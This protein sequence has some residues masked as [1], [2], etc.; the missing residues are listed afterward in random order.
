M[1]ETEKEMPTRQEGSILSIESSL[2]GSWTHAAKDG[3]PNLVQSP[4]SV[5]RRSFIEMANVDS[6]ILDDDAAAAKVSPNVVSTL[7]NTKFEQTRPEGVKSFK[8]VKQGNIKFALRF[9]CMAAAIFSVRAFMHQ[10]LKLVAL[11]DELSDMMALNRALQSTSGVS[12]DND[13]KLL[14]DDLEYQEEH[15]ARLEKTLVSLQDELNE[16]KDLNRALQ[17]TSGASYDND[18]KVLLDEVEYQEEHTARL[19]KTLQETR[20]FLAMHMMRHYKSEVEDKSEDE[21]FLYAQYYEAG[22]RL[23][24]LRE[25]S[26][27]AKRQNEM[28]R[29]DYHNDEEFLYSQFGRA[30]QEIKD[31]KAKIEEKLDD[32][33][34][35]YEQYDIAVQRIF[36]LDLKVED[37]ADV[38]DFLY[39]QYYMALHQ[40]AELRKELEQAKQRAFEFEDN[41]NDEEFLYEQFYQ[42]KQELSK[43]KEENKL[44]IHHSGIFARDNAYLETKVRNHQLT[45][46][47]IEAAYEKIV[48]ELAE[49]KKQNLTLREINFR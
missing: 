34:F 19:E 20:T 36:E 9:L 23:V 47:Q 7:S 32:E 1:T 21:K 4:V 10:H 14:L 18:V 26:D 49:M 27:Q 24:E 12:Y 15:T 48:L 11:Q 38:A 5:R 16:M 22:N 31:L 41:N 42:M 43:V 13:V 2:D 33:E 25:E 35:L 29:E 39:S 3:I 44:N 8:V 17:R 40:N 45:V 37:K 28:D 30:S 46:L 6:L